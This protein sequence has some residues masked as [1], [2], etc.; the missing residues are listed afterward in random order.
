MGT[1][2][3]VTVKDTRDKAKRAVRAVFDEMRRVEDLTSFHKPSDLT[4]INAS[5]GSGAMQAN[6]ELVALVNESLKFARETDGAFDPTLGPLA[7]LWNFSGGEPRLPQDSEIKTALGK[8]GW[9][10]VKTDTS[11]GSITLPE[12]QMSL[13]L[14][15]IAKGYSLDR[16]RLVLQRLGVK[17]A[18]INAGG[19]ILAIGEKT[20]GKPWRIG[21]QDPRN[22]RGLVAVAEIRDGVIVTSGDYERFFLR[23]GKRYHHILNPETGYPTTGLRSVTI[24]APNGVRAD[25]MATAI[26]GLGVKRALEY[27]EST[28]G[29]EGFL[30]DADGKMFLSSGAK[31]F[32]EVTGK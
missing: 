28:P 24:I 22:P 25:A 12:K 27:M 8:K 18:L 5:A 14:G 10:R 9:S 6:P 17:A 2:V 11:A 31:D 19:D 29:V 1:F 15:G 26:F 32:V 3:E 21:V 16:A 13:D 7:E 20:P 30:I 4:R 23:D